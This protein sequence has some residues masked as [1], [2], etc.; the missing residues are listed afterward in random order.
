[1]PGRDRRRAAPAWRDTEVVACACCGRDCVPTEALRS[2]DDVRLCR[3]CVEWLAGKLGVS[4]TPTLP[5]VD[6]AGAISFYERAGFGVRV[7]RDSE[8]GPEGDFAF[9]DYDGQSVFDLG[10]AGFD[11]SSNHA[12]CYLI[13]DD[14]DAWH[15]RIKTSGLS[16]TPPDDI[17][18]DRSVGQQREDRPRDRLAANLERREER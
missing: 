9:V 2:R 15:T 14:V 7:Y 12:G 1:M 16:V 6:L 17:H 4:S 11:P 18:A 10:V 8:D 13:V 3:D 5:V